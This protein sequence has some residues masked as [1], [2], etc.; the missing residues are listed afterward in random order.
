[1]PERSFFAFAFLS[2]NIRTFAS[3]SPAI[4]LF[5]A[6]QAEVAADLPAGRHLPHHSFLYAASQ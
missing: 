2:Y 5:F 3:S 4:I 6:K 1:M